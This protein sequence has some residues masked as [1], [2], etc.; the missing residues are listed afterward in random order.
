MWLKKGIAGMRK[1]VKKGYCGNESL[2]LVW[3]HIKVT[4]ITLCDF[5]YLVGAKY[6]V[7]ANGLLNA[8][9]N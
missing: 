4:Q 5:T 7:G 8:G 9:V 6:R 2:G 1:V 3:N